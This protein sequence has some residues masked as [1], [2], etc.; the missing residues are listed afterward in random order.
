MVDKDRVFD[1]L[2]NFIFRL[3]KT[4]WRINRQRILDFLDEL[5]RY[6][7]MIGY[8]RLRSDPSYAPYKEKPEIRSLCTQLEDKI[9]GRTKFGGDLKSQVEDLLKKLQTEVKNR[10][11]LVLDEKRM[12]N[13][14]MSR[15]FGSLTAGRWY[16]CPQGHYYCVTE[17]GMARQTAQCPECKSTIG[18]GSNYRERMASNL[19]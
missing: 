6:H 16:T 9:F 10:Q 15:S 11:T 2:K 8:C 5:N 13:E 12:I 14:A 7:A 1:F 19:A 18:Q 17:C 3:E 4:N